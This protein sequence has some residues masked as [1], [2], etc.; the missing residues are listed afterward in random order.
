MT[1]DPSILP[2]LKMVGFTVVV[3]VKDIIVDSS[4][5][6]AL[7]ELRRPETHTFDFP[8]GECTITLE[9]VSIL[10]DLRINGKV[11]DGSIKISKDA[12]TSL[13]TCE[14]P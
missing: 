9:D 13:L 5:I 1:D 12:W 11:V 3:I 6:L 10:L 4:F 14:P 8:S 2:Y 7:L